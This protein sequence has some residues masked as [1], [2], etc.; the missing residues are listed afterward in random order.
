MSQNMISN[1]TR[2]TKHELNLLE[3]DGHPH[4]FRQG[5]YGILSLA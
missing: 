3:P 2:W 1:P 5:T 4:C